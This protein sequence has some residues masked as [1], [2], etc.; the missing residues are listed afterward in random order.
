MRNARLASGSG[1]ASVEC[2]R[3]GYAESE[4][5]GGQ[6]GEH[7]KEESASLEEEDNDDFVIGMP[8]SLAAT[9]QIPAPSASTSRA[10]M[11]F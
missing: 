1:P 4:E 8:V 5:R 6:R 9:T 7:G 2:E 11:A 10:Q 3:Q